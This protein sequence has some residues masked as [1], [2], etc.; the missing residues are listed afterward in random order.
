MK[1]WSNASKPYGK[2]VL[3]DLGRMGAVTRK[4]FAKDGH[5]LDPHTNGSRTRT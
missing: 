1:K 5:K 3:L 4:S 2:P